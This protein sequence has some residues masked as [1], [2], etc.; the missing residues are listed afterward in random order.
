MPSPQTLPAEQAITNEEAAILWRSLEQIPGT[1]REPLVLFYREHQSIAAVA[2]KLELTEDAVKQR[3]SRGRKLL[4]EQVLAFVE[5]AL[6]KTAP[7]HAFTAAVIA[8]LPAVGASVKAATVGAALAQGGAAAKGVAAAT[9][10]GALFAIVGSAYVSLLAQSDDSKSPRERQLM[11]RISGMRITFILLSAVLF[12]V[13][14]QFEFFRVPI[15]FDYLAAALYFCYAGDAALL[16]AYQA[17]RR[18]QIQIEEKTYVELEWRMP[19]TFTDPALD[20]LLDS[21]GPKPNNRSALLRQTAFGTI[22]GAMVGALIVV[23]SFMVSKPRA[24][25]QQKQIFVF[26]HYFLLTASV[27]VAFWVVFMVALRLL[28]LRKNRRP[29][30][31]QPQRS[32]WFSRDS[33]IF[34]P[35]IPRFVQP[36]RSRSF[37]FVPVNLGV[38]TLLMLFVLRF[39]SHAVSHDPNSESP[40][41]FLVFGLVVVLAYASL[42]GIL[43]W[44]RQKMIGAE[45][46]TLTTVRPGQL[47]AVTIISQTICCPLNDSSVRREAVNHLRAKLA[48]AGV[49]PQGGSISIIKKPVIKH[50]NDLVDIEI[51]FP[52]PDNTPAPD[53]CRVRVLKSVPSVISI[54]RGPLSSVGPAYSDVYQQMRRLKKTPTGELRQRVLFYDGPA[55]PNNV[56]MLETPT[57]D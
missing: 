7:S 32:R 43:A 6:E 26:S 54:F 10:L 45:S 44:N 57:L 35:N 55:S 24:W 8:G 38:V 50:F 34:G 13:A 41:Q 23:M 33:A 12:F 52:V 51:G 40:A 47:K 27:A 56:F 11:L 49:N 46:Y 42:I 37:L 5:G 14:M 4:H 28:D 39:L 20:S 53:G 30:S 3:L 17:R 25:K 1:Y 2:E 18:Q 36:L 9:S 31:V 15:H 16:S 21:A 48:D 29:R 22:S 19:R